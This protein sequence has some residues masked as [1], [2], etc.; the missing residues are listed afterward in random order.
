[1]TAATKKE[2]KF[3]VNDKSFESPNPSITGAQIRQVAQVPA[4]YQLFLEAHGE[5]KEDR[6]I[7]DGDVVDL[8]AHGV[9]KFFTVPP[10]TFGIR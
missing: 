4:G 7:S 1:M 10:A 2:Y 6:Q 5:Q 8:A 9:E 3:L